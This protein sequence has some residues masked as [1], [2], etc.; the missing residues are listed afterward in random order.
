MAVREPVNL[1]ANEEAQVNAKL[2]DSGNLHYKEIL[3]ANAEE[4]R[5]AGPL[6]EH[7]LENMHGNPVPQGKQ[8]VLGKLFHGDDSP[9]SEKR[10]LHLDENAHVSPHDK[11]KSQQGEVP[12]DA[13]NWKEELNAYL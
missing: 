10:S 5:M 9:D 4:S 6:G 7:S 3:S 11:R 8:Q 1:H 12:L 13:D 2:H